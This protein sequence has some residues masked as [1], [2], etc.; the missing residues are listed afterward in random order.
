MLA[1]EE[2]ILPRKMRGREKGM[3]SMEAQVGTGP[4]IGTGMRIGTG[5]GIGR[6]RI[7]RRRDRIGPDSPI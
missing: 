2:V 3:G 1:S 5:M 6:D 4:G 7:G